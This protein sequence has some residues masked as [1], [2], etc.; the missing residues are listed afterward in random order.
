MPLDNGKL[1]FRNE[2]TGFYDGTTI[3]TGATYLGGGVSLI[4]VEEGS[5]A[6]TIDETGGVLA[7][8]T[9]TGDNNNHALVA[10]RFS[11]SEGTITVKA[12]WKIGH[13]TGAVFFGLQE[14]VVIATPVM[15]ATFSSTTMTYQDVGGLVGIQYDFDGT[16]DDYRAVMGDSQVAISDSSNGIRAN[17]DVTVDR[18]VE[19]V[20]NL[21][22]DGSAEVYFGHV[23]D[24]NVAGEPE[25][26][27]VKHFKT[28]TLLT[29]TDIFTAMLMFENR[30]GDART[31]EVDVFEGFA[32]RN[33]ASA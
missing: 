33:W 9:D 15:G 27:L 3:N 21:Y 14:T 18:W 4:G 5:I 31:F 10:G 16:T 8:T 28:G 30:S 1:V 13:L 6:T 25:L 20:V 26:R 29:P 2:F 19:S 24:V 17:A 7:I 22:P 23:G 32:G 11:P 12:R